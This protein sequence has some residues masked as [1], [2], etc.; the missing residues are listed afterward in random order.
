MSATDDKDVAADSPANGSSSSS[1]TA[2]R[3]R[4]RLR[5]LDL[6][7]FIAAMAVVGYHATGGGTDDWQ[8]AGAGRP[9]PQIS[10]I[11]HWGYLGVQLFFLISGFVILMSAWN[12]KPE[13]FAVS[14]FTRLFPA[15]WFSLLLAVALFFGTRQA[16]DYGPGSQGVLRRFLPNLTMLQDAVGSRG[17]ELSYWTLWVELRFYLLIGLLLWWGLTV[18]RVLP[19]MGAWLLISVMA[20]EADSAVL[21]EIFQP[22]WAPYFIAGMTFFLIYHYGPNMLYWLMVGFCWA[23][24]TYYATQRIDPINVVPAT[25]NYAVPAIV[26]GLFVVM[27]LVSLGALRWLR[28]RFFVVLGALTY[29]VYLLHE[30]L[31]MVAIRYLYPRLTSWAVLG[32]AVGAILV[33]S[34]LV[35]RLVERPARSRLERRLNA[36]IT[37]LRDT[38]RRPAGETAPHPDADTASETD[39][40][41]STHGPSPEMSQTTS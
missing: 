8:R 5:E 35:Y 20:Q 38:G 7:R 27:A 10:P 25:Q 4:R 29:P 16:V 6:L 14:R 22:D 24:A 18:R 11:M 13:T 39:V 21:R 33:L 15:Y 36:A 2:G 26:T 37:S 1:S 28:W 9:F 12:R 19:F 17:M 32:I 40:Q 23:L 41:R 3:P 30:M 31:M 34:Y